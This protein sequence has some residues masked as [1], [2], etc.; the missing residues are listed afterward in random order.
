MPVAFSV[1][2]VADPV[3]NIGLHAILKFNSVAFNAG[4]G[5]D[6]HTGLFTAPASGVY[7]FYLT[8]MSTGTDSAELR[9]VK[10][11]TPL[12]YAHANSDL[13]DQGT[14]LATTHLN[15]GQKVWVEHHVGTTTIKGGHWTVFTGFL[16]HTD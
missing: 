12:D 15:A 7:A 16:L 14:L 11:G 1:H 8:M 3:S 13:F 6:P 9:L 5:Y 4:A 2:F 10:E